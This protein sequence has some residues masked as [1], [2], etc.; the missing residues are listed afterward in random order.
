MDEKIK[1]QINKLAGLFYKSEG[2]IQDMD[3]DYSKAYHPQ[4]KGMW[5]KALIAYCFFNSDFSLLDY[6]T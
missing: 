6:Q 2:Y 5:N 1:D 4:E 3:Y